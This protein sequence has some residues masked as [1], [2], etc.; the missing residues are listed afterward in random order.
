VGQFT[1]PDGNTFNVEATPSKKTCH[2]VK[3][4][5]LILYQSNQG[6]LRRGH[7]VTSF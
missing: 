1:M 7:V 3:H 4:A 6:V 5:G 2:P